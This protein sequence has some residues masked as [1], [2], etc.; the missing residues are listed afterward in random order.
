MAAREDMSPM[1]PPPGGDGTSIAH[2]LAED[3]FP[4]EVNLPHATA[5]VAAHQLQH[6]NIEVPTDP[7]IFDV[8]E[9]SRQPSDY[10]PS[11]ITSNRGPLKPPVSS[12]PPTSV[13][14]HSTMTAT[15]PIVLSTG[16]VL[17]P[18]TTSDGVVGFA[19]NSSEDESQ[20]ML[21]GGSHL[22]SRGPAYFSKPPHMLTSSSPAIALG[23][24][25]PVFLFS[26]LSKKT[27]KI[28]LSPTPAAE[29]M[30]STPH[31]LIH[32]PP[33][34]A[35]TMPSPAS[36][37]SKTP[38]E[39]SGAG[40]AVIVGTGA[41][42]SSR[43][44]T[45]A[46][47][48]PVLLLPP[49]AGA[50]Q[51]APRAVLSGGAPA[52]LPSIG[53]IMMP[54]SNVSSF[55]FDAVPTSQHQKEGLLGQQPP[56]A[57]LSSAHF[58]RTG[59]F[60]TA[61]AALE[62]T[63]NYNFRVQQNQNRGGETKGSSL[64][65]KELNYMGPSS[66]SFQYEHQQV[67]NFAAAASSNAD[68]T[69]AD[70]NFASIAGKGVVGVG[71][72]GPRGGLPAMMLG[73]PGSTRA[74]QLQQLQQQ[75]P[76]FTFGAPA[77]AVGTTAGPIIP[78]SSYA[79]PPPGSSTAPA[80]A[81]GVE[82]KPPRSHLL[83]VGFS[84]LE[85]YEGS[86]F[87]PKS[88]FTKSKYVV[89]S[90]TL[91][92]QEPLAK[93][94]WPAKES[95]VLL[96]KS[97]VTARPGDRVFSQPFDHN[98]IFTDG[99]GDGSTDG[100]GKKQKQIR[101][102][103]DFGTSGSKTRNS[104]KSPISGDAVDR[105]PDWESQAAVAS[106]PL[107]YQKIIS[108]HDHFT[109][110]QAQASSA[111][112]SSRSST[113]VNKKRKISLDGHGSSSSSCATGTLRDFAQLD[114]KRCQ[115]EP[116]LLLLRPTSAHEFLVLDVW[117]LTESM[118]SSEQR[119]VGRVSLD[120]R[121]ALQG[122]SYTEQEHGHP[123]YA[124]DLELVG[125]VYLQSVRYRAAPEPV[126]SIFSASQSQTEI[127]LEWQVFD[128]SQ[129]S[130]FTV[131]QRSASADRNTWEVVA[132]CVREPRFV[133][134]ENLVGNSDYHF[135]VTA[136]NQC[137]VGMLDTKNSSGLSVKTAPTVPEPVSA[138]SFTLEAPAKKDRLELSWRRPRTD[139]GSRILFYR[140]WMC[141]IANCS[142][143][144]DLMPKDTLW[145]DLGSVSS[146]DNEGTCDTFACKV[147]PVVK[148]SRYSFRIFAVNRVGYSKPSATELKVVYV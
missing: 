118:T 62:D 44:K 3:E 148:T 10:H 127:S 81:Q 96:S 106:Y 30:A 77:A 90:R 14:Q 63:G 31:Q 124:K 73:G 8:E 23:G 42:S 119:L 74:G 89:L 58:A 80:L 85:M 28:N 126:T 27:S 143:W 5:E 41:A 50:F 1:L 71:V 25:K 120:L 34:R 92:R 65:G 134:R 67:P 70:E 133:V 26:D 12:L 66:S 108:A 43:S 91:P 48:P 64:G 33:G 97:A 13:T 54:T 130:S 114:E 125:R 98:N 49:G 132:D 4:R 147:E 121:A 6:A 131:F 99:D 140:V 112:A 16:R 83:E 40:A 78:S 139:G 20:S 136:N 59:S 95:D 86:K 75:P 21:G 116:N 146:Y 29:A 38:S 22:S 76:T 110:P 93:L 94:R 53:K 84:E 36:A 60:Q 128:D 68:A 137:G 9:F 142:Y 69:T 57:P 17:G 18:G 72:A 87:P 104:G 141:K 46:V 82:N 101:I 123:I 55:E 117:L 144:T 11:P 2:H 103:F 32:G 19:P 111:T 100:G 37:A 56:V 88:M 52:P 138:E 109:G 122:F 35:P 115:E 113:S 107:E 135:Q 45:E 15:P 145:T 24:N 105:R 61:E 51:P 79:G 39:V 129:V 102:E 47:A 7:A